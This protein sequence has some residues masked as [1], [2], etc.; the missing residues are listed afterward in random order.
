MGLKSRVCIEVIRYPICL[1]KRRTDADAEYTEDRRDERIRATE[2]TEGNG[3]RKRGG[4]AER[5]T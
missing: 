4:D 2:Y 5:I 3:T 1:L